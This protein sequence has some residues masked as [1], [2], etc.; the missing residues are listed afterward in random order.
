MSAPFEQAPA[1]HRERDDGYRGV[2]ARL[3]AG[4][5]VVVCG[6][7]L[8][9]IVQRRAGD[10]STSR[11]AWRAVSFHRERASLMRACAAFTA[12]CEPAAVARLAML[13]ELFG[14]R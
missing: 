13:P 4:W 5:R 10:P 2:V 12:T 14:G 8:Q 9:W 11:A 3:G 6:D 1:S 7:G